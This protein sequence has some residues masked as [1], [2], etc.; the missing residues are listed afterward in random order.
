MHP[1]GLW[2]EKCRGLYGFVAIE[3]HVDKVARLQSEG[4]P[5]VALSA[6][7]AVG[8]LRDS[9]EV[10]R[11]IPAFGPWRLFTRRHGN[12]ENVMLKQEA[13]TIDRRHRREAG[14]DVSSCVCC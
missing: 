4:D 6:E 13:G 9:L 11:S 7:V 5:D 1:S 12:R 2:K 10:L 14:E 8:V 3:V